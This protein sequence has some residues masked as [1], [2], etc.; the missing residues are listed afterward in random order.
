MKK[1]S[2]ILAMSL[3]SI[4][5]VTRCG[6]SRPK[7]FKDDKKRVNILS[8]ETLPVV[9]VIDPKASSESA[10]SDEEEDAFETACKLYNDLSYEEA[11][12]KY[13]I[14]LKDYPNSPLAD[15]CYLYMGYC[16]DQLDLNNKA[17]NTFSKIIEDFPDSD[18]VP[19]AY[20]NIATIYTNKFNELKDSYLYYVKCIETSTTDFNSLNS[21]DSSMFAL[22]DT[23]IT[24]DTNSVSFDAESY[25][26]DSIAGIE[27]NSNDALNAILEIAKEHSS[28]LLKVDEKKALKY[29]KDNYPNYYDTNEKMELTMYYGALLDYANNDVLKESEIGFKALECVKYVYRRT[30]TVLSQDTQLHLEKL[31]KLL[32]EYLQYNSLD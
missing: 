31:S 1:K 7:E 24:F 19:L 8:K 2:F 28:I 25:L 27:K 15:D 16:Y 5:L 11:L 22:A 6:S 18:S 21:L 32:N 29:I 20:Y 12:E 30:D 17:V 3:I 26:Q 9:V 23:G 10:P 14:F 13:D 4:I